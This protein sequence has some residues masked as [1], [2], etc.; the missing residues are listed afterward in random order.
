MDV[1]S[2]SENAP[3]AGESF[4]R[5]TSGSVLKP[6]EQVQGLVADQ[7]FTR[8]STK[9]KRASG[10]DQGQGIQGGSD[11]NTSFVAA[12]SVMRRVRAQIEVLAKLDVPVLIVGESGTGKEVIA[13]L[14]H[15][16]SNRSANR[17]LKVSCSALEPDVLERALFD[18]E[19]A[20]TL[21]HC[22]EGTVLLDDIDDMPAR[23]QAKLLCLLQDKQFLSSTTNPIHLD[24]R[25]LASTKTD[26][27]VALA[28]GKLRNDLYYCLSTFTI[29]VP[30]LRQRK[31][32]I[33]IFLNHFM[34]HVA[35]NYALPMRVFS[36][37]V[38]SAC[39]RYSWPG[40][41]RELEKF[42]KRYMVSGEEE[43]TWGAAEV[44]GQ[45]EVWTSE[46]M[47]ESKCKSMDDIQT[48]SPSKSLL[49]SVREEAERNAI[50]NV[51]EQTRWN[52]TAAARLLNVSYRTLLNKI[53]QYDMSP[54][55]A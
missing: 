54:R 31:D 21:V 17:F 22:K 55:K 32:E 41:L 1:F 38:V 15:A 19:S 43:T 52:R 30:P 16:M 7:L 25:I 11:E 45:E 36:P 9:G 37:A 6:L 10:T 29:G 12:N 24:V 40:N 28:S 48:G 53:Q 35:R 47:A 23:A 3:L 34:N 42:V 2:P 46:G 20:C 13:R 50:T 4:R 39:Q 33:P 14:I 5:N 18:G 44:Y 49:H 8:Q 26:V 51:L 27:K